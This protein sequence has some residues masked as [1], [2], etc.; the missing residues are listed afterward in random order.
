MFIVIVEN[1][2]F[3]QV[4]YKKNK[5]KKNIYLMLYNRIRVLIVSNYYII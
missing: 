1:N 4:S 2:G 3:H 5:I